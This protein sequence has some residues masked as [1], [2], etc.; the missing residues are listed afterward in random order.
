MK[1]LG[2]LVFILALGYIA[3]SP[4]VLTSFSTSLE[5]SII[6]HCA[7]DDEFLEQFRIFE[8]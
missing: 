6:S 2:L 8:Q 5:E 3:L 7:E 4:R 1:K